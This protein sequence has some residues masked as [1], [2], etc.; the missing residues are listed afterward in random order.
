MSVLSTVSCALLSAITAFAIVTASGCGTDAKGVDSCRD[1]EEA[2]CVAEMNCGLI[3]DVSA[4]QDY[5]RDQCLHGLPVT[6]PASSDI[7]SCVATIKAAGVCALQGKDTA[8][9]DCVNVPSVSTVA[10]TTCEITTKPEET[11]ECSFLKPGA[12]D[13]GTADSGGSGG[14]SSTDASAGAGGSS[15]T[16]GAAAAE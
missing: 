9:S 12:A 13:A 4:C 6:P 11:S 1:I 3:S 7:K 10:K 5:Y 14:A 15:D 2:R 8:P 16:G